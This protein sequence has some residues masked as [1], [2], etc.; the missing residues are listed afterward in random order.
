VKKD[1]HDVKDK[2]VVISVPED[3]PVTNVQP[4]AQQLRDEGA[5]VVVILSNGYTFETLD[6][7]QLAA[8]GLRRANGE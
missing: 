2:V 8:C 7:D 6:D 4:L 5:A 1:I 3:S